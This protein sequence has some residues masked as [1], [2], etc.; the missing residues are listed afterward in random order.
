L[1]SDIHGEGEDQLKRAL[2]GLLAIC[3]AAGCRDEPEARDAWELG[4]TDGTAGGDGIN[5]DGDDDDDDDNDDDDDDDDDDDLP[6]ADDDDDDNSGD[7][8]DD[9]DDDDGVPSYDCTP[10]WVTP[11]IGSPCE[12]DADCSFTD[13]FCLLEDEGFPC[14]TCSQAC[15][16]TCPDEPGTPVTYCING[17]D[18]GLF[19]A[20]YCLSKCDTD[21]LFGEGCRDGYVCNVLSRFDNSGADSVCIPDELDDGSGELVDAIDHEFLID[22]FG[23]TVVDPNDYDDDVDGFQA[24]LDDVGVWHTSA[25]EFV[26]PHNAAAAAMCGLSNLLPPRSEW[27]KAGALGLFTDVLSELVG[28]DIYVRNWWRPPCYNDAVGGAATGDHPDA[29]A[30]DLDFLSATSRAEA[31]GFLCDEYWNT[32]I[33]TPAEIAPGADVDP[34]L[35]MSV[36]LGGV[37]IHLGVLS[38]GGRR[39]WHYASYTAQPGS[40]NCW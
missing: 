24:Y 6:D 18:V 9:D 30:L 25:Q 21:L 36:G 4:G 32:P 35:N 7:D 1:R 11:W 28:E 37:T 17:T 14:G 22:H 5:P 13:G 10:A 34:E 15:S 12:S 3:T 23:G 38:A 27:E 20:G 33:V 39:F 40:G 16:T 2:I 19:D 26:E 31:Q 29:D 8:D